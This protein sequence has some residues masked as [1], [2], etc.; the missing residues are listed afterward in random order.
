MNISKE[1]FTS[2]SKG[3]ADTEATNCANAATAVWTERKTTG[4]VVLKFREA[5]RLEEFPN[6]LGKHPVSGKE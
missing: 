5:K 6:D 4:E 3:P 2:W 1:S